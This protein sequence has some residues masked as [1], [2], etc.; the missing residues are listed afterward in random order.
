LSHKLLQKITDV[1]IKYLIAQAGAGANL[2]QVF[3]SWSGMLSPA[4]FQLFALPY[5][6]QISS[7][8]DRR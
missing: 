4:D 8:R 7:G 6:K 1:T 2:V 5:L 3:D